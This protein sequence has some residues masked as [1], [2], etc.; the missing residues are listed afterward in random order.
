V[1]APNLLGSTWGIET[2]IAQSTKGTRSNNINNSKKKNQKKKT[3]SFYV[4]SSLQRWIIVDYSS[5]L[6]LRWARVPLRSTEA[7][8]YNP[9]VGSV[10][11]LSRNPEGAQT[12]ETRHWLTSVRAALHLLRPGTSSLSSIIN[13]AHSCVVRIVTC[14]DL[15][16]QTGTVAFPLA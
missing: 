9:V 14:P 6:L 10:V 15:P 5:V 2:A 8:H 4:L 1:G 16:I 3:P 13:R 7:Q 11:H 12:F